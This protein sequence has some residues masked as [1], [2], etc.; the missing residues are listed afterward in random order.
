MRCCPRA[1]CR[2]LFEYG[3]MFRCRPIWMERQLV[4]V[5]ETQF[6]SIIDG[7]LPLPEVRSK[8]AGDDD[9]GGRRENRAERCLGSREHLLP[10]AHSNLTPCNFAAT[11]FLKRGWRLRLK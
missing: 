1:L 10:I 7:A 3:E 4:P 6:R 5:F 11:I 8:T 9:T 2:G